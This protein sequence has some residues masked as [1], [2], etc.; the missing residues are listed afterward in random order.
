MASSSALRSL[1]LAGIVAF[2]AACSADMPSAPTANVDRDLAGAFY[3]VGNGNGNDKGGN[4]ATTVSFAIMPSGGTYS[5]GGQHWIRVPA[6][7]VCDPL[8]SGY[9]PTLWDTPCTTVDHPVYVTATV[10]VSQGRPE[11]RFSPDIRFAPAG[12]REYSRWVILGLKV[13][14]KLHDQLK[15][16]VWYQ[17]TGTTKWIDEGATDPTLRAW[18]TTGNTIARRLK[19]FSGYVIRLGNEGEQDCTPEMEMDGLC[20]TGG[21]Q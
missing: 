10:T 18:R 19:H 20:S 2:G 8:T 6:N 4:N 17:P 3:G 13:H 21:A 9:G 16:G 12:P 7:A 15:Y 11:V 1:G 5:L 14:G